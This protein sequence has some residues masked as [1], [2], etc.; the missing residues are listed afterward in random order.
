[1]YAI[2]SF[3]YSEYLSRDWGARKKQGLGSK[4]VMG[5]ISKELMF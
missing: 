4:Q 1:M 2:Y 5:L 3:L